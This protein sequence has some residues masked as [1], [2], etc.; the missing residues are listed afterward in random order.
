MIRN[1]GALKPKPLNPNPKPQASNLNPK[2]TGLVAVETKEA[3]PVREVEESLSRAVDSA[4][5]EDPKT[6]L[7]QEPHPGFRGL[8]D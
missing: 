1:L 3:P 6:K 4:G 5:P 8:G 2:P 7:A